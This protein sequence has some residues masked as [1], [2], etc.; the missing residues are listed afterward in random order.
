MAKAAKSNVPAL[1]DNQ[2]FLEEAAARIIDRI[3]RTI[4]NIIEVGRELRAVKERIGHGNFQLWIE[5]EFNWGL[6]TAERQ[7]FLGFNIPAIGPRVAADPFVLI[8]YL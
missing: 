2:Q 3:K 4:E 1:P 6:K 5:S 8:R 7:P